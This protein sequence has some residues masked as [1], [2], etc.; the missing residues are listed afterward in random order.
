MPICTG[1]TH[2][3]QIPLKDTLKRGGVRPKIFTK[4]SKPK[5]ANGDP[6][7]AAIVAADE[8]NRLHHE[9]D[10]MARTAPEKAIRIG[11]LLAEQHACC[12]HGEWLPWLKANVQFSSKTA[13]N[14]EGIYRERSKFV[15]V[16]NL[17]EA[18]RL[19]T[20]V[21]SG[22]KRWGIGSTKLPN[23]QPVCGRI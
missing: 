3:P 7:S 13:Y 11:E 1:R 4:M 9:I 5:T 15:N 14:Y 12:K 2:P 8:I 16:T 19:L 17:A 20:V 22:V 18:Y 6:A 10:N 23:R 21:L